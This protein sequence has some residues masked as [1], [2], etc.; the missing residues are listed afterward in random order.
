MNRSR[1][2]VYIAEPAYALIIFSLNI[3]MQFIFTLV[4]F[5]E[6]DANHEELIIGVPPSFV[7]I[8]D[9]VSFKMLLN[10]IDAILVCV[11]SSV[12]YKSATLLRQSAASSIP[13]ISSCT[14]SFMSPRTGTMISACHHVM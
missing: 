9:G 2:D 10:I 14:G 7:M 8:D 11:T 5:N 12:L 6:D 1:S 13:I 4:I 3:N